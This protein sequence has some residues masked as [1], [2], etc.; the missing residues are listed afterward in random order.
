W[1][2]GTFFD[3]VLVDAPCSALGVIR[4][5]PD[6]KLLRRESDIEALV[7][8]QAEI[9]EAA[10]HVLAVGGILLYATCSLLKQENQTQIESFLKQHVD[11]FEIPITADWGIPQTVGRQILTGDQTMDGFYYARLG[12]Q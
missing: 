7:K 10:W 4:H 8:R 2:D 9:L 12:K 3:R 1:W 11:S 5:H 6:I